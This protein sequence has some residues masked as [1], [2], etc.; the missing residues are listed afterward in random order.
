VA[1]ILVLVDR[2]SE[3]IAVQHIF[4][5]E[6]DPAELVDRTGKEFRDPSRGRYELVRVPFTSEG[7]AA[8]DLKPA[9]LSEY[10]RA[11]HDVRRQRGW[12]CRAGWA[13]LR[14][15]MPRWL[16]SISCLRWSAAPS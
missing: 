15:P 13:S 11:T 8:I 5:A 12:R 10:L 4:L 16:F 7:I 6:L 3:G 2:S 9:A 1:Q 14:V